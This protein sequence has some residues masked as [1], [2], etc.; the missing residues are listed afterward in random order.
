MRWV[1][2]DKSFLEKILMRVL[3]CKSHCPSF[4][5]FCKPPPRLLCPSPLK[6]DDSPH[7]PSPVSPVP[8][9]VVQPFNGS[10]EFNDERLDGEQQ[11]E[12][13]PKSNLKKPSSGPDAPKEVEKARVQWMD[14]LGK[15]LVEVKE[16]EPRSSYI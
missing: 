11:A 9:A 13:F 6:L 2:C 3:F 7:V 4:I 15:E 14:F 10:I 16:F 12:N 1:V 8:D 5:C